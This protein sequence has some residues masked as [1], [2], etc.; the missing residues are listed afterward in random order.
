VSQRAVLQT[1][2]NAEDGEQRSTE[3]FKTLVRQFGLV[4]YWREHGWPDLCRPV[5]TD[6]FICDQRRAR[7]NA[8][9]GTLPGTPPRI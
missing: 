3:R 7:A 9:Y 5:G 2:W 4:D 6:D 1:L 8:F